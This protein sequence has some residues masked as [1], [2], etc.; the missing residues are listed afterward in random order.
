MSTT[1]VRSSGSGYL[2]NDRTEDGLRIIHGTAIGSNDVTVG[3]LT[4]EKKRWTP[5]ALRDAAHT[6][7]GSDIVV[8][9]ENKDAYSKVGEV[10]KARFQEGTGVIY[11]GVI[12]DEDLESK[13]ERGWLQVS[14]RILHGEPQG[15]DETGAKVVDDV[16][17]FANL[18]IVRKGAAPSNSVQTG[19]HEELSIEELRECFEEDDDIV[20]DV[21]YPFIDEELQEIRGRDLTRWLYDDPEGAQ[22]ASESLGCSGYH[23]HSLKGQ[24]F[25][26]PCSTHEDFLQSLANSEEEENMDNCNHC[27]TES[28]DSDD[29]MDDLEEI[30]IEIDAEL[31][32]EAEALLDRLEEASDTKEWIEDLASDIEEDGSE[33]EENSADEDTERDDH[34]DGEK[35]ESL[36][37]AMGV[38]TRDR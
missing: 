1:T 15:E 17:R 6:L 12:D 9:H 7:Q 11:E 26:M 4:G 10:R 22:G 24:T 37:Q 13:I 29:N 34:P 25:Y 35:L 16:R 18:S 27:N 30:T 33:V 2:S 28:D 31:S 19:E 5:K 21:E 20:E 8:N 32:E 23:E 14:P 36:A 38:T 3:H